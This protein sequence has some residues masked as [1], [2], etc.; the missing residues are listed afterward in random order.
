MISTYRA[1]VLTRNGGLDALELRELPLEAPGPG[2]V[3][4]RVRATG[5]GFTDIIMR[6]GYHPDAPKLPF[7][8]GYEVV[9]DVEAIGPGVTG[10][11]PGQRVAALTVHGGYAESII[12]DAGEF[13]PVPEGLDDAEVTALILNYV[14]AY[15]MIHRVARL[16]AGQSALV[17]GAGGGVGTALLQLLRVAG[18][19]A[20]G[21]DSPP[22]AGLVRELGAT[23]IDSRERPFD[24]AVR[25]RL[26]E[27][28][29]VAFDGIG[30]DSIARCTR[31]VRRGGRLISY[32]FTSAVGRHGGGDNVGGLSGLLALFVGTRLL[33]RRPSVYGITQLYQKDPSLLREDLSQLFT[34]LAERRIQPLIAHR[35]PLLAGR[36]GQELLERGGIRGKIILLRD[37]PKKT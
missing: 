2:Q 18:V 19:Q 27:G 26:P 13:I 33:G 15:Q 14:T 6:R 5:V 34:L 8:P 37:V 31:A 1:V 20:Y 17:T 24:E 11:T 10:F 30:G 35:L 21:V 28:V 23:F 3:R 25:K 36:A 16:R 32:G 9:G 7:T 4:L 12:R 22:K 29:D